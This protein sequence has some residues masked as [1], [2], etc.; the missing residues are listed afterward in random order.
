M[1]GSVTKTPTSITT[2]QIKHQIHSFNFPP[3]HQQS[4]RNRA[5]LSSPQNDRIM[6][7]IAI[8]ATRTSTFYALKSFLP[9][10]SLPA[11]AV[12]VAIH[13]NIP[14]LLPGVF[15]SIL[16]AVPK[17]KQSHSRKRMRQ[18]AGKALKDVNALSMCSSC[19][20]VKRLHILCEHC[21]RGIKDMWREKGSKSEGEK[22]EH[23]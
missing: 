18:L 22:H 3:L 12:P 6:A 21:V 7:A 23:A 4:P 10:L 14:T 19:G 20:K 8:S 13:L 11:F 9:R 15:E 2:H 5:F 16:R 1:F 17:K